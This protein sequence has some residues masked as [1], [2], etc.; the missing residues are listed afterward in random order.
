MLTRIGSSADGDRGSCRKLERHRSA[1]V[2]TEFQIIG[3]RGAKGEAPENTLAGFHY[4]KGLGL[5]AIELDV[6]LSRDRQLVV[7]HDDTV[8]RTTNASGPVADLSAEE[9][10]ALDARGACPSWPDRVGVP[11]LDQ[12]LDVLGGI[13]MIQIELKSDTP[14]RLEEIAA[15]VL[16]QVHDRGTGSR[17]VLSSF[18]PVALEIVTRLNPEQPRA[19]IGA[20]DNPGF[21]ED[22]LRLGCVQA[23][24]SLTRGSV[25]VVASARQEGLRVVGFQCNTSEHLERALAWG[26]DAATSDVPSTIGKLLPTA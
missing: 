18:D 19:Y 21:L 9:L 7:I 25:E 6:R 20:Y 16:K 13:S 8:D 22:A 24:I 26:F 10:A 1:E 11:T 4:A 12:V 23:D 3:H 5:N 2:L 14:E 17:I 15:G